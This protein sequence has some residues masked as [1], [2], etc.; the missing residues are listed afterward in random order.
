MQK[1]TTTDPQVVQ[2]RRE[3]EDRLRLLLGL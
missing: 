2:F 1:L 3:I